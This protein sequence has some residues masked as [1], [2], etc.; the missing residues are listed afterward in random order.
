MPQQSSQESQSTPSPKNSNPVQAALGLPGPEPRKVRIAVPYLHKAQAKLFRTPGK[1]KAARCGRRWGKNVFGETLAISDSCK[2]RLVGWFAPEHKRLSE[3][4][5]V[6]AQAIEGVK[7]RRSKTEGIIETINGGKVEFWSLEDENAG[8]SRKYHRIIVDEGAFTKPKAIETL[9]RSLEPTLLDYDGSM[10]V[11]SNT[12][13]IEPDNLMWALCN[14][15]RHG[16]VDFHAPTTSNPVLPLRKPTE[17]IQQWLQRREQYFT[18]LRAK[19]PPLV[20]QQEYLAEFVDWSGA[21]FFTRASLLENE[22]PVQMPARCETVFATID[23]ATKTG[24]EHD[25]TG[26][27]Y[28]AVV[29]NLIRAVGA[30][31]TMAEPYRLVILDWDITQIEG[32]LLETWLPNVFKQLEHYARECRARM[33]STGAFIEDKS[34]GMVLIQHAQRKGWPVTPINGDLTELASVGKDERAISVSG[35]VYRGMVKISKHAYD[36][37]TIYKETTRNHLLG[38]VVGFRI[39]DKTPNRSDDLFDCFAYG[40]AIALGN[41]EGF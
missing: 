19:T 1:R 41:A 22:M 40:I 21:A 3:S 34:S 31:G 13:G 28:W 14:E 5:N 9:Q 2:G 39:G 15:K 24:K 25:G 7:R 20:Y 4:Y 6:I 18:E 17:T 10:I 26:V 30:D 38:Q 37:V 12:N 23:T 16:F 36:K 32:A 29:K 33:G 27:I 8:R 35:Y 11:M